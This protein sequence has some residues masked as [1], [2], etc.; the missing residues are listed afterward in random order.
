MRGI[1]GLPQCRWG[2][3]SRLAETLAVLVVLAVSA[4]QLSETRGFYPIMLRWRRGI[5][6]VRVVDVSL[7]Q[8]NQPSLSQSSRAP[9]DN[10]GYG[11]YAWAGQK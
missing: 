9:A 1:G 4:A 8:R 5:I 3:L 10:A 6:V 11:T 2:R 7:C